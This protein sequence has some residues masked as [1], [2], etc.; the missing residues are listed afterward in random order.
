MAQDRVLKGLDREELVKEPRRVD[1]KRVDRNGGKA[2]RS[3]L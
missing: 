3:G 2:Q 1:G